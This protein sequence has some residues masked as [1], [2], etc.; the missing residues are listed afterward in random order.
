MSRYAIAGEHS[1]DLL[2]WGGRVIVHNDRSEMEFLFPLERIVR[3]SDGDIGQTLLLR[4]H[5]DMAAV[6]WPLDPRDF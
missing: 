6:M 5:P 1:K 4:D 2:T 3:V